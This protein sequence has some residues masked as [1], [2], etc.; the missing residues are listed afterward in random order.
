[1]NTGVVGMPGDDR[2]ALRTESTCVA[3]SVT[4]KAAWIGAAALILAAFIGVYFKSRSEKPSASSTNGSANVNVSGQT[5]D[6]T[7]NYN[8]PE[9]ETRKAIDALETK[10]NGA[11]ADIELTKNE[12]RLLAS[13]LRDLDQRTSG[14]KK[15]PDGRTSLGGFVGGEPTI[16][17]E[18]H[19]AAVES[20]Q[21]K[22]FVTA[23]EHSRKAIE[24]YEAANRFPT[25]ASTGGLTPEGI[26][27]LYYLGAILAATA[28]Q[29]D[30]AL[31]WIKKADAA[32]PQPEYKA[33]EVGVLSEAGKKDEARAL[34]EEAL[35]TAPNNAALLDM[36]RQTG[37]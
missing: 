29:F 20:F 13:A 25:G 6:I 26:G 32:S 24:S 27:K 7:I 28:R 15:L 34:L 35:K 11:S 22:D 14:I 37:L 1:M 18:E 19:Q 31:D 30:S 4:I 10:L 2:S 3:K 36:K 23:L 17:L 5:R 8:V 21:K 33:V 9:S 12:V 16:T